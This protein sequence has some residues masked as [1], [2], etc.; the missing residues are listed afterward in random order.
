VEVLDA[1]FKN[2]CELD[3]VFNFYKCYA[4]LDEFC[5]AGELQDTSKLN[6]VTRLDNLY[7][8]E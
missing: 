4:L 2:V 6:L 5:L 1:F 8:L 3:L 7:K